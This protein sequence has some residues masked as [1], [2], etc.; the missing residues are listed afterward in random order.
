MK[1]SS[2]LLSLALAHPLTP[3]SPPCSPCPICCLAACRRS[4]VAISPITISE[5]WSLDAARRPTLSSGSARSGVSMATLPPQ[6]ADAEP[7]SI[8]MT[9]AS[10][11]PWRRGLT[12]GRGFF[13]GGGGGE[14]RLRRATALVGEQCGYL[15]SR[16]FTGR[17]DTVYVAFT[18]CMTWLNPG[19]ETTSSNKCIFVIQKTSKTCLPPSSV[20]QSVAKNSVWD[21]L[22][23][24]L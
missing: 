1:E 24:G 15:T 22:Q 8:S 21:W 18:S 10:R 13:L 3:P 6:P 23:E 17:L 5:R 20:S 14:G 19:V 7:F 9:T 11:A 4:S 2:G 16:L 12:G